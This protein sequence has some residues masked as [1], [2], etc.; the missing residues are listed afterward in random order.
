[1]CVLAV[2]VLV[3][4]TFR[5]IGA[6]AVESA[7][8]STYSTPPARAELA[9]GPALAAVSSRPAVTAAPTTPAFETFV[10]PPTSSQYDE[11]L[12]GLN[13]SVADLFDLT[14]HTIVID[15]GHGGG[16]PGAIGHDGLMEKDV[17]L[18][19]ARR[20]RDKLSAAGN[21][22]AILTR[23]DDRRMQLKDRVTFA[24]QAQADL[25]ISIHVNSVPEE[26]GP[27]NYVETY[28]FGPHA[29]QKTLD[30]AE[31]E[32]R[33]SDYAMGDFRQVI[34]RIGDTLK[35]EESAQLAGAMHHRLYSNLKHHNED[36]LDAGAKSGPFVVLLGVEVPSV[37]I[38]ISCISNDAEAA[39]LG[40]PEYRD[41]IASYL[42]IGIVEYLQARGPR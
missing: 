16:D 26:A 14:V 18:D 11:M 4:S 31:K 40:T 6:E 36:L 29:D 28:Y 9:P 12:N 22:H 30:L 1:L 13:M 7:S 25:F 35:T 39:R 42:E 20:L 2:I 15:P 32:N 41:S 38:E 23:D 21:Y 8:A 33:D 34:A 24:K 19:V 27:V 5:G 10:S 37:L 3:G 17:A